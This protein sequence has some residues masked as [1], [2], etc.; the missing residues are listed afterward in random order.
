MKDFFATLGIKRTFTVESAALERR[1]HLLQRD[2][3]PDR[4]AAQ[5]PDLVESALERSSDINEAYRILRDPMQRTKH[6]LSLYGFSVEQAKKVPAELLETVMTVQE[7]IAELEFAVN[8][9]N[10]IIKE[11]MKPLA[12]ELRAKRTS[13]DIDLNKLRDE[14]DIKICH[15]V[16]PDTLSDTERS[17][18]AKITSLI[19]ERAYITTLLASIEAAMK[20]ESHI[21]KH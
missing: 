4:F 19:A 13:L 20:G 21:L 11:E 9:K 3:H 18:L 16:D 8:G 17:I 5:H 15:V 12:D 6:L 1:F 14:W 10:E 2:A 7:K